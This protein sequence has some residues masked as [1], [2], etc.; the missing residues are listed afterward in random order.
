MEYGIYKSLHLIFLVSWFAGLFYIVRLFIYHVE[1]LETRKDGS[2]YLLP[3]FKLM[4][5]RLWWI[6]TTPAMVLTLVFGL[7]MLHKSPGLVQLPWMQVKLVFVVLLVVYH[8]I[9]QK[10]MQALKSDKILLSSQK[11]RIWNEVATLFLVSIV[12]L[13]V[14][15]STLDWFYATLIFLSTAGALMLA[16]Q[17]YKKSRKE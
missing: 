17:W 9:C 3:Q 10:L 16:I 7:M 6:I 12:F 14:L 1:V 8:F 2:Q 11:L 5:K 4:Q 15:K 13:V